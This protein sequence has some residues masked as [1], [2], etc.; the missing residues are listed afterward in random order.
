MNRRVI[1]VGAGASGLMAAAAAAQRGCDVTVLEKNEKAGKK[2]Y[3]TGKGRCNLTN[4]CDDAEFF[5]HVVSNPKFLYSSIY[6]FDHEAVKQFFEKNG[7]P[8]KTE[9]GQR[10]FP[11]S[12]HAS[13]VTA[14]L[15]SAIRKAGGRILFHRTVKELILQDRVKGVVLSDGSRMEA[16]AV[17]LATG[18]LSYPATG[19]TG[20]G[21]G[22]A[23]ACG[24]TVTPAAPSL[25]P[26]NVKEMWPMR[27][28]G[29]ALRNIAVRI[30]PM[31]GQGS[32]AEEG[33]AGKRP[34]KH[35][36]ERALYEGFGEMLFT[37]FGISGPLILTASTVC[38]F[39]E[40]PEGLRLLL[41]LKPAVMQTELEER[42]AGMFAE[43]PDRQFL[44]AIRPLFPERL[45][46]TMAELS[47]VDKT[48]PVR[49]IGRQSIRTFTELIKAVP[50]TIT[51]TRGFEEAVITKGGISVKE[52]DPSTME[53][54]KVEGLYFAG[55]LID[56]D[57]VTGGFNLQI[58]WSTG[59][60]AG[61]SCLAE[62]SR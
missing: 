11:V 54:R 9:R 47:G 15:V 1:I 16:D 8:L 17:I 31:Q 23:A 44:H 28:Q 48:Q 35:R 41:D 22:I 60:L 36:R 45:A 30:L 56:V 10:V 39:K 14:A 49:S 50:M 62:R 18:G 6:G 43:Q 21:Y 33:T 5:D 59:H 4:D 55:E 12:D 51:G 34:Q 61:T 27:L 24:H 37:H 46:E 53:S 26:F 13:D 29:L 7:C 3:I 58:A 19:S 57:A 38:S 42:I 32:S 2:I 25:V 52:I 20:D 40:H